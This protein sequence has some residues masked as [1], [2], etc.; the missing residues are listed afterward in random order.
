VQRN[1]PQSTA[2]Q[3]MAPQRKA[4]Q[5]NALEIL[6]ST[7][8]RWGL[9]WDFHQRIAKHGT[10]KHSYAQKGSEQHCNG[11][12][13]IAW[14]RRE[15]QCGEQHS[16]ATRW[17]SSLEPLTGALGWVSATVQRTG[18]QSREGRCM[19]TQRRAEHGKASQCFFIN[20]TGL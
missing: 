18:T 9:G 14:Q 7:P 2:K 16:N 3:C 19:A 10:A 17:V 13:C 11:M 5:C 20:Y 15:Q 4:E 6:A 8:S 1:V 12:E